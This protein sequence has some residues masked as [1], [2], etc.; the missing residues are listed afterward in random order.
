MA[1][2]AGWRVSGLAASPAAE[3]GIHFSV[4]ELS[5]PIA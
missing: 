2:R 1:V 3:H 4:V 5:G